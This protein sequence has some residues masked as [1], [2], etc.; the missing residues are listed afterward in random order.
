[1]ANTFTFEPCTA[2]EIKLLILSLKSSKS[3]GPNSIPVFI[4]Q[5]L[6][7]IIS[8]H[9]EIIFNL[10]FN[11]GKHPNLLKLAKTIAIFKKG[12]KLLTS[13]Y[14]PISLLSNLNKILE[15]LVFNRLYKFLE[16][17]Q[18]IYS[19]QFGFRKKTFDKSRIGGNN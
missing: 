16:E 13:N 5:L 8:S 1:M 6:A 3:Y 19:L 11:T 12:S 17:S 7:D 9:L 10:S 18:C 15:K 2:E 4:L 14:R